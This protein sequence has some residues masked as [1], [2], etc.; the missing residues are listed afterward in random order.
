MLTKYVL[1]IKKEG[2]PRGERQNAR[3]GY[4]QPREWKLMRADNS[5]YCELDEVNDPRIPKFATPHEA[6]GHA[7]CF[8]KQFNQLGT[9]D[10]F[11]VIKVVAEEPK[12]LDPE[13]RIAEI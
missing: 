8:A 13:W 4:R 1:V 7:V 11:A 2:S 6:L 3:D 10:A 5:L 12:P 9:L